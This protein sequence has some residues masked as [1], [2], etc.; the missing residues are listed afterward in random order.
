MVL[1]VGTRWPDVQDSATISF[2]SGISS[3]FHITRCFEVVDT[4]FKK[5]VSFIAQRCQPGRRLLLS[6]C[7]IVL[8]SWTQ[9]GCKAPGIMSSQ[10]EGRRSIDKGSLIK[11]FS[12]TFSLCH[13]P[14]L[15]PS[16]TVGNTIAPVG[17]DQ[18]ACPNWFQP[19]K[20]PQL[21]LHVS[22]REQVRSRTSFWLSNTLGLPQ[23]YYSP[24]L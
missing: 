1:R 3:L 21:T 13:R 4:I 9:D 10:A 11:S 14:E 15:D 8:S 5:R 22:S 20:L 17:F 12:P 7:C 18:L 24:S 6:S 19:M 16:Q 2:D 23:Q